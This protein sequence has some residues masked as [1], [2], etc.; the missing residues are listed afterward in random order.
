MQLP[1]LSQNYMY[2]Q[3]VLQAQKVDQYEGLL[4]TVRSWSWQ[5]RRS[6]S[7]FSKFLK[8]NYHF[9]GEA[10]YDKQKITEYKSSVYRII[11][12]FSID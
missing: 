4:E 1:S 5:P 11:H 9:S 6:L 3:C 8:H 10:M 12:S 2:L 7:F